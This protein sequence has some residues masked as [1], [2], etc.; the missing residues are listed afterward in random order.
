M[1]F[2]VKDVGTDREVYLSGKLSFAD[3]KKFREVV[4]GLKA[5]NLRHCTLDMTRLESIDSAGLGL[6]ILVKDT[7]KDKN[8]SLCIRGPKGQ[9]R[10]MLEISRFGDIISITE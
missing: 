5:G 4:Q 8:L 9:V 1:D 6:L 3:H 2:N 7:A 10:K